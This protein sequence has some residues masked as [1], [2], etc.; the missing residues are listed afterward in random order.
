V[1]L[2]IEIFAFPPTARSCSS[3]WAQW[4]VCP[5]LFSHALLAHGPPRV[6]R[7]LGAA[8]HLH[9]PCCPGGRH[10][11]L[12][13]RVGRSAPSP[14]CCCLTHPAPRKH[15]MVW[16]CMEHAPACLAPQRQG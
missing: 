6:A 7:Q 10:G 16:G 11:Q 15:G 5:S 1:S 14:C 2:M 13:E 8:V 3:A 9:H 12:G 4:S